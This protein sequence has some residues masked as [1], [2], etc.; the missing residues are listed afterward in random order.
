MRRRSLTILI[1]V[2]VGGACGSPVPPGPATP[3]PGATRSVATPPPAG[4][5]KPG[6]TERP[7]AS[8]STADRVPIGSSERIEAAERAGRL[9]RDTAALYQVFA[10]LDAGSLSAEYRDDGGAAPEATRFLSD[11]LD[12]SATLSGDVQARLRP[13]LLR[14]T[15]PASSWARRIAGAHRGVELALARGTV[16]RA[17]SGLTTEATAPP[18]PTRYDF[19][20]TASGGVRVWYA[21]S[22]GDDAHTQAEALV[23][24]IDSSDMWATERRSLLGHEPCGDGGLVG[25]AGGGSAALDVYLVPPAAGLDWQGRAV[26]LAADET[27]STNGVTVPTDPG[28]DCPAG[29]A[30]GRWISYI[31]L[32]ASLQPDRLRSTMAHE[33]FHAFQLS[34]ENSGGGDRSWW[35]EA[36]ATWAKDLVYPRD[37]F[38]QEYLDGYWSNAAFR[39]GPLDATEGLA[40]Y[41]AYLWP[42][43]LRQRAGGDSTV[44]GRLWQAS[45]S[46]PPIEVMAGLPGWD[47][48]FK[49]FALWNWN[50][51][52][53]RRYRDHDAPVPDAALGQHPFCIL[54]ATG[55]ALRLGRDFLPLAQPHASAAYAMGTPEAA[56]K[57]LRFDLADVKG[58][59]GLGLQAIL[60]MGDPGA[61]TSSVRVEDWSRRAE[62]TFCL[63][64]E[65]LR[66]IV[67]VITNSSTDAAPLEGRIDVE[68]RDEPCGGSVVTWTETASHH[69]VATGACPGDSSTSDLTRRLSM[70]VATVGDRTTAT[71][72]YE[73]EEVLAVV[74]AGC[75]SSAPTTT[76]TKVTTRHGS[77]T[78]D[79]SAS[80]R[81][82]PDGALGYEATWDEL[83]PAASLTTTACSPEPCTSSTT[84]D[85]PLEWQSVVVD[86]TAS[87]PLGG[88]VTGGRTETSAD[89]DT[90]TT[91]TWALEP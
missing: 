2:V 47:G 66:K 61:S 41:A 12:R 68:G 67:L 23:S 79:A 84:D 51:E 73:R 39:D 43:F 60:W 53:L 85:T 25:P 72:E 34:F 1:A 38:E 37:D 89:G 40:E 4:A 52:G 75:G 11:L 5:A 31:A 77:G 21:T 19:V 36:T 17:T 13:F 69:T 3:G 83:I 42:F 14:P 71:V 32:D 65:D 81:I 29:P 55:C 50:R 22:S 9:D 64:R 26:S 16:S 54:P 59:A 91:I 70:V 87:A 15:D 63:A 88:L 62:R 28:V 76:Y 49:A 24:E 8:P 44:V 78:V 30:H 58:R 46:S 74:V 27:S 10:A 33:L 6:V 18:A 90:V 48:E 57:L 80:W 45:E 56:V 82:E 7:V 86:G 35:A 20:D